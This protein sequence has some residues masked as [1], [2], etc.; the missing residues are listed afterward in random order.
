MQATIAEEQMYTFAC[1]LL[2]VYKKNVYFF[3]RRAFFYFMD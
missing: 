1:I 2:H 3:L